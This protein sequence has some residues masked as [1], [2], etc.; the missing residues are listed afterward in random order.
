[1][2][3]RAN[4]VEASLVAVEEMLSFVAETADPW[5]SA[6]GES[7]MSRDLAHLGRLD[8]AETAARSSIEHLKSIGD[9]WMVFE[10]LGLLSMLLEAGGDLAGAAAAYKEM[11]G[12]LD[13]LDLPLYET[14]WI[15]RLAT[16]RARQGD[17]ESALALFADYAA[18]ISIP[19]NVG[20]S[21]IGQAGA[22]RRLGDLDGAR[23]LLDEA[24]ALYDSIDS[25]GGRA[26]AF[27]GLCWWAIENADFGA[28][29][30]FASAAIAQ[31]ERCT[32]L[33]IRIA[34]RTAD[35]AVALV[36]SRSEAAAAE[37]TAMLQERAKF[38]AGVYVAL[39]G[40]A[41]SATL[42]EPD[43]AALAATLT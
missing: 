10:G 22:L 4:D 3:N 28:A 19:A 34:A 39:I 17:E 8:E 11:L 26:V 13:G 38:A 25:E 2:Y 20:W 9:D 36:A 41:M 5:L 16:V 29:A 35:A 33:L 24:L 14:Q 27:V 12:R 32:D 21:L 1:L 43:V 15:M 7:L 42:D 23:R 37:W 18:R 40:G 31:G 30:E 6:L